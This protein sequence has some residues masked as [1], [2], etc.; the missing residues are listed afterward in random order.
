MPDGDAEGIASGTGDGQEVVVVRRSEDCG[1]GNI[2]DQCG[3]RDLPHHFSRFL[4]SFVA[5]CQRIVAEPA[6][7]AEA[8]VEAGFGFLLA[9]PRS[10]EDRAAESAAL[11]ESLFVLG[12]FAPCRRLLIGIGSQLEFPVSR[13]AA[14]HGRRWKPVLM[15]SGVHRDGGAELLVIGDAFRSLR[16]SPRLA[17]C[18][19]QHTG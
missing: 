11:A 6:V 17:Q 2:A 16:R 15:V 1:V 7:P 9:F 14:A 19:K 10:A 8:G 5:V 4:R 12:Q 18:R 13:R 3:F